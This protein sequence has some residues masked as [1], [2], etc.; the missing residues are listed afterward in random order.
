MNHFRTAIVSIPLGLSLFLLS[1]Y[2][3]E[4]PVGPARQR[5]LD[6]NRITADVRAGFSKHHA[7]IV[8]FGHPVIVEASSTKQLGDTSIRRVQL[9]S[10]KFFE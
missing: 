2:L 5:I 10:L 4:N 8:S 3:T 9:T 7:A 1:G 6:Q